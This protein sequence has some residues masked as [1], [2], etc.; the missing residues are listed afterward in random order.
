[1]RA[2]VH[3][4]YGSFDVLGVRDIEKP[5]VKNDDVLVRVQAAGLHVGDCFGV[6]GA[7]FAMRLVTGLFRPKHGVLGF[8]RSSN[9]KYPLHETPTALSY[10]ESGHARGKV[11]IALN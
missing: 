3:D 11:V 9:R 4:T 8:D 7:P 1:M 5:V 2:V 6:R 10:I